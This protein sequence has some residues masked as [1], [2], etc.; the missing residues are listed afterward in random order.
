MKQILNLHH[1]CI[2]KISAS[3]DRQKQYVATRREECTIAAS[4]LQH[5]TPGS[6]WI[7]DMYFREKQ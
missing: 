2:V 3:L 4:M 1:L 7:F 5:Q 6:M